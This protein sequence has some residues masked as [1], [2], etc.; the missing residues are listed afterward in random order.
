[1]T[2]IRQWFRSLFV[3][4]SV[5]AFRDLSSAPDVDPGLR[6]PDDWPDESLR[7]KLRLARR[8]RPGFDVPDRAKLRILQHK[9]EVIRMVD[10]PDRRRG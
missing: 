6:Y 2:T 3:T 5:L 9:A 1:M 7:G 10:R 4:K 8:T